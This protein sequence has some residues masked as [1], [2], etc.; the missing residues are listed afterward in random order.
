MKFNINDVA[1]VKLT[2]FGLAILKSK[3]KF[4]DMPKVEID[5][6][7]ECSIWSLMNDFGGKLHM[8]MIE[9]VFED[10][11]IEFKKF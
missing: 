6:M 7:Y 5:M 1:I 11:A 10:N 4:Y 8:G 3:H 2:P 9:M